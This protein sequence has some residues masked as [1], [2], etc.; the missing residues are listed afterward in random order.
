M[1]PMHRLLQV[2]IFLSIVYK[3]AKTLDVLMSTASKSKL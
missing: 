3:L 2:L 1:V